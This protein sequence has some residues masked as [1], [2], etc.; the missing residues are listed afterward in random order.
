MSETIQLGDIAIAV[1]RKEIKHVHLSVHPPGGHVTLAAP[2]ATRLEVAH[3]YAASKLGWI[4]DQQARL[5]EQARETPRQFVERESHLLW[6]AATC[7]P[8]GRKKSSR[9]STSPTDASPSPSARA[10]TP[11]SGRQ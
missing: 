10:A 5:R 11:P 6:G 8:Y 2:L 1:T 7:S 3:A 4:R 9:P